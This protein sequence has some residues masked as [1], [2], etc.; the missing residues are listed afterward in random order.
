MTP[1]FFGA[2]G[3]LFEA[4]GVAVDCDDL[5]V[6][7]KTIDQGGD[8]GRGGK[9]VAPFGERTIGRHQG[10]FVLVTA[11]D[12]LIQ[13]IGMAV[14]VGEIS[15]LVDDQECRVDIVAQPPSQC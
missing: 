14:R 1:S 8:A 3:C 15:D 2:F 11:R 12:E 5:G 7:D 4:V 9:D 10:A 13:Q 6:V